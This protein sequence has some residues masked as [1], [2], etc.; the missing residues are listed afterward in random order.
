MTSSVPTQPAML[1][2]SALP[3]ANGPL[4]LG[5]ALEHIQTDIWVRFQRMMGNECHAVCGCDAHGTATMI[6]AQDNG[7]EPEVWVE[8]MRQLQHAS[9]LGLRVEYDYY[10]TTHSEEN[11]QRAESIYAALKANRMIVARDIEQ[12]YD[13][14]TE[15]FLADR[16]VKG[17]CPRCGAKDQNGDNCEV[18]GNTYQPTDLKNPRSTYSGAKPELRKSKQLFFKLSACKEFL[19]G[20]LAR[21]E[22]EPAVKNKLKEWFKDELRDWDISREKP[23]FG[24]EIP[25][26]TDKFFYVWLDA[27]IGY[28]AS[29][30]KH[31]QQTPS[32]NFDDFWKSDKTALYHFIGKDIVNFHGLFWPAMLHHAGYRTP[33][34]I[35]VH[36]YVTVNGEKM[37]KSRGT[38]IM[39]DT[40][41]EHLD[42]DY[43]RYYFATKLTPRIEDIDF[44]LDD[45][46][47]R[48]NS[49]IVGKAINIGSRCAGFLVKSFA[50]Q[51]AA[52]LSDEPVIKAFQESATEIAELYHQR[53]YSKAVRMI[54]ALADRANQ[55]IDEQQPWVLAKTNKQDPAIQYVCSVGINC[56]RYLMILLKPV[57]PDLA[58]KAEAFL[59]VDP[60]TWTDMNKTLENHTI[61]KFKSLATRIEPEQIEKIVEASTLTLESPGTPLPQGSNPNAEPLADEIEFKD[62]L[63]IDLRVAKIVNAAHVDGSDKL[64]RLEL[65]IGL[66]ERQVFSGIK[67]HYQPEDIKDRLTV[68]VANLKPRKMRFGL[69]EGMV[70]CAGDDNEGLFLIAPDTGAK[71]G[72]RIL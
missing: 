44:N 55:Y 72:Q 62:F 28:M 43:L 41:L 37:S 48:V 23:Y 8:S 50:G 17:D 71:P 46:R 19:N 58:H 60:L 20:W 6:K 7:V 52:N 31:C 65:D 14:K 26:E 34:G 3:Y 70:L 22:L 51:L 16:F 63:K 13:P 64:L 69:S 1:V 2:T 4:H 45:F 24:F 10:H 35:F 57:L 68:V 27:P 29:F 59:Q 36:G 42:A 18:C 11:R 12:L 56:F 5:H 38:F 49:D 30:E 15:M 9:L 53:E 67:S 21:S 25:G 40:Y 54:F 66:G 32:L 39:V 47:V 33:T 61:A